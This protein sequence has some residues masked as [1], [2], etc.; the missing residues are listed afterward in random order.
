MKKTVTITLAIIILLIGIYFAIYFIQNTTLLNSYTK[1]RGME[2]GK[3]RFLIRCNLNI[4]QPEFAYVF[5]SD[6]DGHIAFNKI[7]KIFY[8]TYQDWENSY[9]GGTTVKNT[10][11]PQLLAMVKENC[12]QFQ[13]NKGYNVGN[14]NTEIYWTYGKYTSPK[15]KTKEEIEREKQKKKEK[16]EYLRKVKSGEIKIKGTYQQLKEK[17]LPE[18]EIQRIMDEIRKAG[19]TI[20]E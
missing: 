12:Y 9:T 4:F 20:Y 10:T 19:G 14:E 13:K 15:P 6:N 11:F 3:E 8:G 18:S 17:G 7:N 5:G 16:E 1:E 2:F